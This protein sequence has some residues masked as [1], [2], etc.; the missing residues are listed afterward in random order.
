MYFVDAL[1]SDIEQLI[2]KPE[3]IQRNTH[4]LR[5]CMLTL[6]NTLVI[7]LRLIYTEKSKHYHWSSK[8]TSGARYAQGK[9]FFWSWPIEQL[10]MKTI[11]SHKRFQNKQSCAK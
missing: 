11:K 7:A 6:N 8:N 5:Y 1:N 3:R 4:W 10:T 9:G 2:G